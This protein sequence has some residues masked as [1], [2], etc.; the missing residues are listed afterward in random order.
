M[1]KQT[2][3]KSKSK[4]AKSKEAKPIAVKEKDSSKAMKTMSENGEKIPK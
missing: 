3:K 2:K 4:G 1:A